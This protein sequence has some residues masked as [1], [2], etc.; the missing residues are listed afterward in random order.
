MYD[1]KLTQLIETAIAQSNAE[2][3]R[4]GPFMASQVILWQRQLS[5]TGHSVDAFK[6]P[7]SF[8]ILLLPWW[9]EKTIHSA[10]DPAF[11][12]DLIRSSIN[13]YYYIRLIDN[14]MDG[15]AT[16]ELKLL[17]ALGFYYT[18]FQTAYYPHFPHDHIF[19]DFLTTVSFRSADVTMQDASLTNIDRAQFK[20]ISAKKTSGVKIPLAA[21]CYKY[22]QPNLIA[23]W[24]DFADVFGRW[25]Q[26][27]NDLFD[28]LKDSKH[29]TPTY[30]LS[31]A[32]R[33]RFPTE[34]VLRWVM[35]EG[36][37]WAVE[38]IQS[39]MAEAKQVAREL[40]SPDL[41]AYLDHRETLFLTR[42]N[43]VTAGLHN[44]AK[45]L[46]LSQ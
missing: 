2:M 14:L 29:K 10:P 32:D 28:W 30:F 40:N 19:W 11:Q 24:S 44:A 17:P 4:D 42:K 37:D 36:F 38:C 46:A 15:H 5:V 43:K 31:E 26:M 16:V 3:E 25:N 7:E 27:R 9:L 45:L 21:V 39:W 20:E 1:P 22:D 13:G 18:Q 41:V 23:P 34:S 6:H 8:P 33:Q 12:L 35:R